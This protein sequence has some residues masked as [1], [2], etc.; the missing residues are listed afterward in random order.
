MSS[1][2]PGARPEEVEGVVGAMQDTLCPRLHR[3]VADEPE[4][5]K[6]QR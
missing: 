6:Q 4:A 3:G 2:E 1:A 5:R